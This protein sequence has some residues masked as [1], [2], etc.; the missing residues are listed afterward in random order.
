[1]SKV[2]IRPLEVNDS[3]I[4]FR[5]RNDPEIWLFTGSKPDRDVTAEMETEW[6]HKVLADS[7][8]KRFAILV[9]DVYVGNVQLTSI[10]GRDAE[11]HIFIGVKSYWGKGIATRATNQILQYARNVLMLESVYL[12]VHYENIKAINSYLKIGFATIAKRGEFLRMS[13]TLQYIAKPTVSVFVLVYNHEKFLH[14]CLNGIL[15][16]DTSFNYDICVG[17]DCSTDNSRSILIEY[18]RKYPGIF[19]I[20]LHDVNVGAVQ[21]QNALLRTCRGE[22]I[23]VCEGDDYWTD[24]LKLQ[25]QVNFLQEN[26]DCNLVYHRVML[27]NEDTK[28]FSKEVLNLEEQLQKRDLRRFTLEG[29]FMHTPSVVFRNNIDYQSPLLKEVIGDY[30]L[31]YLN[32]E[33]GLFGYIP[34]YMAVYRI[35]Q[36]G[37]WSKR[38]KANAHYIFAKLLIRMSE[39]V[40]NPQI[41]SNLRHQSVNTL[42]RVGFSELTIK[43]KFKYYYLVLKY[44]DA[45]MNLLFKKIRTKLVYLNKI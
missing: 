20:L 42:L 1:M 25:K 35:S 16:Q 11:F 30:V 7:T 31:W 13:L 38:R 34:D 22:Y 9:D 26:T 5:W 27:Y 41:S 40:S 29:N 37:V 33:K 32:G 39:A 10:T 15:N 17:E 21:N 45:P 8:S 14:E 24:P 19:K 12:K 28:V 3:S 4:S 2:L 6:I 36:S 44:G 18:Q 43:E 23:A